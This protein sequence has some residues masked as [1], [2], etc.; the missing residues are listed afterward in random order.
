MNVAQIKP[1]C[2]VH[3]S[4]DGRLQ[5]SSMSGE[6]PAND[7]ARKRGWTVRPAFYIENTMPSPDERLVEALKSARLLLANTD[8]LSKNNI[9]NLAGEEVEKIDAALAA[10]GARD[11]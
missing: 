8:G 2:Y 6:I 9:D 1:A 4:P 7:Q 3:K 5:C 10:V 11:A